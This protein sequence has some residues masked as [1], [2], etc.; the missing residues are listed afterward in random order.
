MYSALKTLVTCML[1]AAVATP[2]S[3]LD[4]KESRER[5]AL[6]RMQQ[7]LQKMQEEKAALEREKAELLEKVTK[8]EEQSSS[9]KRR[10]DSLEAEAKG[11]SD[12]L[13]RSNALVVNAQKASESDRKIIAKRSAQYQEREQ[14][15]RDKVKE[16]QDQFTTMQEKYQAQFKQRS[17]EFDA[18]LRQAAEQEVQAGKLKTQ[19]AEQEGERKG[20][21]QKNAKLH[22]LSLEVIAR[23]AK[24]ALRGGEPFLQFKRVELENLVQRFED[25]A[26]ESKIETSR[27]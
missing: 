16:M 5:E 11:V 7:S 17:D 24:D 1:V 25:E 19:L 6:R 22:A 10:A 15:F 20:C 4:K 2:A 23:Y 8:A 13:A 3:A 12:A 27:R 9:E 21:E 14:Q 26:R 18:R